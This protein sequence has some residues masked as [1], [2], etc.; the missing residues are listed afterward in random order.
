MRNLVEVR[1]GSEAMPDVIVIG[2]AADAATVGVR[3]TGPARTARTA[4]SVALAVA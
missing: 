4:A 3:V 1:S 2:P